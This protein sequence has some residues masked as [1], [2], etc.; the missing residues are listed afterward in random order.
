MSMRSGLAVLVGLVGFLLY[1]GAAVPLA[2][3][4]LGRH[5]S[6]QA[7]YFVAAG[8]LWAFPARALML[9]AARGPRG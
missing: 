1:L 4:L 9:W 6:V 3:H 2:D 7:L 5:R 8:V